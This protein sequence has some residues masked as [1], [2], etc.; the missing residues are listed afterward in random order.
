MAYGMTKFTINEDCVCQ[1]CFKV[2]C[3]LCVKYSKP[4]TGKFVIDKNVRGWFENDETYI[5]FP[6]SCHYLLD[7][8]SY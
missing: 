1:I 7:G 8:S 5:D 6:Y 2:N 3:S 4:V